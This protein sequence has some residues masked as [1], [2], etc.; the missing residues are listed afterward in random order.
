M[1]R[2]KT[3]I[4]FFS[5]S[6]LALVTAFSI[7]VFQLP[8]GNSLILH[9][10]AGKG[11]DLVGSRLEAF[12][13]L[14]LIV[15]IFLVNAVLAREIYYRERFLSYLIAFITFSVTVFALIAAGVLVSVN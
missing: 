1:V 5:L 6:T 7:L 8:P 4:V 10:N 11:I 15:V 13:A 2:D 14:G 12:G 3:L 9:F